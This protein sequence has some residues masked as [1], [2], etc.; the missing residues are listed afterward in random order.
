MN[1]TVHSTTGMFAGAKIVETS[2]EATVTR[3]DGRIEHLGTISY[4]HKNPLRRLLW[5]VGR[6]LKGN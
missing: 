6:W 5:R 1:G 4:Y 3:A 2:I